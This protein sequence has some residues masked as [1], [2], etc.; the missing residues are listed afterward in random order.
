MEAVTKAVRACLF[1]ALA[2]FSIGTAS[3]DQATV[4]GTFKGAS[5]H[6]T[7]GAVSVV[8]TTAGTNVV[9]GTDFSLDGAPDPYVGLG[10]N[11]HY[12]TNTSLGKLGS[13]TGKQ[14]FKVPSNV[15]AS[16]YNEVYIWCRKFGVPLGVA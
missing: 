8:K 5:N 6:V 7:S 4:S 16:D 14:T 3:A 11:G 15:N 13:E 10:K 12:D 2:I 1:T 9:L